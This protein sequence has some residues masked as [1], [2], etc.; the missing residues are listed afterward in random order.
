MSTGK[1]FILSDE[2]TVEGRL[3][4]DKYSK[5]LAN[6]IKNTPPKFSV[7][8]FGEWWIE[9]KLLTHPVVI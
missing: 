4:F 2:P 8:V 5:N 1:I 7:G 3:G 9:E 6:I